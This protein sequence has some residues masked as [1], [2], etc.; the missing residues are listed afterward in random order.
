VAIP[1]APETFPA[2]WSMAKC[3]D[4]SPKPRNRPLW[5]RLVEP[6]LVAWVI[7]AVGVLIAAAQLVHDVLAPK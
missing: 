1:C 7:G 6:D 3:P 4:P 2:S 5:R